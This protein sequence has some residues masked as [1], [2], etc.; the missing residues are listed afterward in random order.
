MEQ[1]ESL[2]LSSKR[3][4]KT[5]GIWSAYTQQATEVIGCLFL[6]SYIVRVKI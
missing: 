5:S 3:T 6:E 4:K 1:N 2:F